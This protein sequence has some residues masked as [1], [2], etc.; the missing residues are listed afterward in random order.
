MIKGIRLESPGPDFTTRVM[1]AISV[2]TQK[3]PGFVT[4]PLLGKR[5]WI[6]VTLF[7][8]LAV[9]FVLFLGVQPENGSFQQLFLKIQNV[10]LSPVKNLFSVSFSKTGSM[11]WTLIIVILGASGLIFADKLF[12]GKHSLSLN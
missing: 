1:E 10:D 6:L 3:Q 2:E 9:A 12:T 7:I 4:E 5:F 11:A 8:G